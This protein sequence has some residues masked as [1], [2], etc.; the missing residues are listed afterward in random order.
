MFKKTNANDNDNDNANDNNPT[1]TYPNNPTTHPTTHPNP[2]YSDTLYAKDVLLAGD[3]L[4]SLNGQF[5]M[6]IGGP[7]GRITWVPEHSPASGIDILPTNVGTKLTM[8]PDGN[9]VISDAK[10]NVCWAATYDPPN[11]TIK[12]PDYTRLVLAPDGN[13]LLYNTDNLM[14]WSAY[15]GR[16]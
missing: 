13:L 16:L 5:R 7:T 15:T 8:Q 10:N 2:A 9:L 4:R 14:W 11:K 3:F 1:I 12:N 6:T